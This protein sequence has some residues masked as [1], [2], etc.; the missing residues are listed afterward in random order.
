M[1]SQR[2]GAILNVIYDRTPDLKFD[3]DYYKSSHIPDSIKAWEKHG[4]LSSYITEP[5][6][7][8]PYAYI[9]TMEFESME[10]W[11]TVSADK[12]KMQSLKDDIAN[13]SNVFPTYVISKVI[14]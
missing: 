10:S 11:E 4:L 12:E 3:M 7:D 9:L 8:A 13:F 2:A 5:E 14:G 1:P 6:K